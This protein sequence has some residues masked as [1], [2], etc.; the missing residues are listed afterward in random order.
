V[1]SSAPNSFAKIF[2]RK[3]GASFLESLPPS[4]GVYLIKD[5]QGDILYVGKAKNLKKRLAQYRNAAAT[6]KQRKMRRIIRAGCHITVETCSSEQQALLYENSLIAQHRPLFNVSGAFH[7][8]YPYVGWRLTGQ[9]S[10][11]L[12][13]LCS[14]TLPDLNLWHEFELCGAFRSRLIVKQGWEALILL[15]SLI[16]HAD[17]KERH[18]LGFVPYSRIAVFRQIDPTVM[19][20]LRSF[21]RGE[22][23][24]LLETL[25]S[26]LIA[27]KAARAKAAEVET[28]LRSL[29]EFYT[30]EPLPLRRVLAQHHIQDSMIAQSE[31]DR[32]FIMS[33]SLPASQEDFP[34][35]N[36]SSSPS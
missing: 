24:E 29:K 8:L 5:E 21:C 11:P 2:D 16:G 32:L 27:R 6:K 33:R 20:L 25:F 13:T 10:S 17:P 31:R 3:F 36:E 35:V 34:T 1:K 19:P 23:D 12:L 9:S 18:Q 14:T 15:L 26:L 30:R 7:F 28:A 4:P 22:S